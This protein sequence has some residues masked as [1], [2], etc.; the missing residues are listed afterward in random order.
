MTNNNVCHFSLLQT[1]ILPRPPSHPHTGTKSQAPLTSTP[2]QPQ[3][4]IS[5]SPVQ[6]VLPKSNKN[7]SDCIS[8]CIIIH[9]HVHLLYIVLRTGD[10]AHVHVHVWALRSGVLLA[11]KFCGVITPPVRFCGVITSI[12]S[13]TLPRFR[14]LCYMYMC[15]LCVPHTI[16]LYHSSLARLELPNQNLTHSPHH[17]SLITTPPSTPSPAHP[18]SQ[19]TLTSHPTTPTT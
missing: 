18:Y 4:S 12:P 7:V 11:N 9:V 14:C 3:D 13:P 17:S 10:N 5:V 16:S 1:P 19:S 6:L 8:M 2:T 15:H